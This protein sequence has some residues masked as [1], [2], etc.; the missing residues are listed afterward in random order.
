MCNVYVTVRIIHLKLK[1]ITNIT[2][3]INP[4]HMLLSTRPIVTHLRPLVSV[5]MEPHRFLTVRTQL[6]ND[7]PPQR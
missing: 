4:W 5:T 3:F 6:H 7:W 2:I 1:F